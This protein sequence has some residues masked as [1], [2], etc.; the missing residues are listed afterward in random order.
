M[1]ADVFNLEFLKLDV[2]RPEIQAFFTGFPITLLHAFATLILLLV[3]SSIYAFLT[4]YKEIRQ[5]KEGNHAAA[6]GFGGV[7]LGLAI[8]L[9]ASMSASTSI[10]EILLW[11]GAT[12][13]LQLFVF[14]AVDFA[15][16]GLPQRVTEGETASAV[17]LVAAKLAASLILAAAV[18]G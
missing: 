14:R 1:N 11:G 16:T 9:A 3:G 8:P 13:I 4:P 5:I 17:L 2:L 7:I 12:I 15:L 18:A 6:V 10:R